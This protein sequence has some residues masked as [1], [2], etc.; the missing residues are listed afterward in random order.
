MDFERWGPT[1]GTSIFMRSRREAIVET[2]V[3]R[4]RRWEEG[5]VDES[6]MAYWRGNQRDTTRG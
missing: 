2:D 4:S 5:E 1:D 3:K 6:P